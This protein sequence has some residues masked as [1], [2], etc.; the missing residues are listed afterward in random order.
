MQYINVG[1]IGTSAIITGTGDFL[2][3]SNTITLFKF[4]LTGAADSTTDLELSISSFQMR[5]YATTAAYLNVVIPGI[6]YASEITNRSNGCLELWMCYVMA[7]D[8]TD[9][10]YQERALVTLFDSIAVSQGVINQ[11]ITLSGNESTAQKNDRIEASKTITLNN[12]WLNYVSTSGALTTARL[13]KPHPTLKAGDTA[14]LESGSI[15]VGLLTWIKSE[16][17]QTIQITEA[18]A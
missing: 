6:D 18:A 14:V 12:G 11:S 3:L 17:Y 16:S 10:I 7:T 9:I 5:M 13:S 2:D 8:L 4:I 1:T 15:T